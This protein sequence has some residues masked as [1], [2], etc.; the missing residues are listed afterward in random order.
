MKKNVKNKAIHHIN[1]KKVNKMKYRLFSM[2]FILLAIFLLYLIYVTSYCIEIDGM[3]LDNCYI[4]FAKRFINPTPIKFVFSP[5]SLLWILLYLIS[6]CLWI[7]SNLKPKADKEWEGIEQ[8]SNHFM[9]D[10]ELNEFL[11]TKTDDIKNVSI[12]EIDLVE[13]YIKEQQQKAI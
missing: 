3:N 6:Y 7:A 12:E 2:F 8:G 9:D 11:K 1:N 4:V 10:K 5:Y 13:N